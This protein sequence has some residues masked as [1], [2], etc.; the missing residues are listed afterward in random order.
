[1]PFLRSTHRVFLTWPRA[2]FQAWLAMARWSGRDVA[3][4]A[5]RRG[6]RFR[7]AVERLEELEPVNNCYGLPALLAETALI[8]TAGAGQQATT[9]VL[10]T[11]AVDGESGR[12][13]A[14]TIAGA[15]TAPAAEIA[16]AFAA[17]PGE[18]AP[19]SHDWLN[20]PSFALAFDDAFSSVADA[21]PAA[22]HLA[23][24]GTG[25]ISFST[26]SQAAPASSLFAA[27]AGRCAA[28]HGIPGRIG[29]RASRQHRAGGGADRRA[30]D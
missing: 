1:V 24:G 5:P 4:R 11:A 8:A 21:A 19:N 14:E 12:V 10:A 13:D 29:T 28:A 16:A 6:D 9:A 7:P 17:Y 15:R 23:F 26:P 22:F 3:R 2:W 18:E 27:D 20:S 30:R 25:H